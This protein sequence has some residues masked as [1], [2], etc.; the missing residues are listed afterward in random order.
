MYPFIS[1]LQFLIRSV[2]LYKKN[3]KQNQCLLL[4]VIMEIEKKK[5]CQ[6]QVLLHICGCKLNV[7]SLF[8][9]QDIIL[10]VL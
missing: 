5:L 4:S 8:P 10:L 1:K 3:N 7:L 2:K 6:S 9:T